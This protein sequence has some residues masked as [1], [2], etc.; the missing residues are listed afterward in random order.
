MNQQADETIDFRTGAPTAGSLDVTWIHGGRSAKRPG[1]PK[2]QVHRYDEHTIILRQ[3]KSVHYEAPFLFLLF[4]NDRVLLLDTGATAEPEKFPLRQT[5]KPTLAGTARPPQDRAGDV[6]RRNLDH[7]R[8]RAHRRRFR[9]G[10][11]AAL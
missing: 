5:V 7:H 10:A 11:G 2:I 4:G 3:S 8:W 6:D 9:A 1:D